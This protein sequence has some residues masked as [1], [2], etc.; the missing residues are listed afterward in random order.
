MA[1]LEE[2]RMNLWHNSRKRND[3]K[4]YFIKTLFMKNPKKKH[5]WDG[6][7]VYNCQLYRIDREA[8]GYQ[9]K[10]L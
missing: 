5:K 2:K 7:P 8:P 4:S 9:L 10:K 1:Q 6:A 3:R